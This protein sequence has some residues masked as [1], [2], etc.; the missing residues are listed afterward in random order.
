MQ[1]SIV[2]LGFALA[3]LA[4]TL[5]AQTP[6]ITPAAGRGGGRG[7]PLPKK[8][9]CPL[10]IL[11]ALKSDSDMVFYAKADVP[12]GRRYPHAEPTGDVDL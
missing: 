7:M 6:P 1:K 10:P 8:G 2:I 12:Q 5:S 4:L 9:V 11:P 3:I